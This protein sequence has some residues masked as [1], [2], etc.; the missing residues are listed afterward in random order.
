M[1]AFQALHA[2]SG[3]GGAGDCAPAPFC[4]SLPSSECAYRL[5]SGDWSAL[6]A[7]IGTTAFR[8]GLI[9]LGMYAFGNEK[10]RENLV[11]NSIAGAVMVEAFVVG[12]LVYT[13]TKA[14]P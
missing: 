4:P 1:S 8:A 14:K 3:V 10:T 2:A 6:P 5:V 13:T 11:R 12:W 7:V 9:G